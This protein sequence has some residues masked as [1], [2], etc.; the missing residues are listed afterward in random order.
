MDLA[1]RIILKAEPKLARLYHWTVDKFVSTEELPKNLKG[2]RDIEYSW[3][4]A[5]IPETG[6]TAL[7]FGSG[8]GWMALAAARKGF[9]V[10]A[11]DMMAVR[12]PYL[13][14]A[15]TFVQ[16][17]ILKDLFPDDTFDLVINVSAIEHVGM[18][19]RYEVVETDP[20]GDLKAMAV[21]K[22]V[23]RAQKPMLL[24]IPIG[25]D[26]VSAPLHRVYGRERLPR[27][28]DGWEIL[29]NEN[30]IKNEENLWVRV[31]ERVALSKQPE[32]A[33]YGLG[34]YVLRNTK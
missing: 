32:P 23:L 11:L 15:L 33:C 5:H 2:D 9:R 12:W 8:P 4:V 19:G 34:L 3:I 6:G 13:H 27:L 1:G 24:T 14:P 7:D 22:S 20:D 18:S 17:D 25:Q 31:E 16:G 26:R 28:L 21:L 30:W 10:T 29:E